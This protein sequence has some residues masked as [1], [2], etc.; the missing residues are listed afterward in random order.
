M[1]GRSKLKRFSQWK[2]SAV[3]KSV[4][5]AHSQHP[6]SSLPSPQS[7][8]RSHSF[9]YPTQ[10]LVCVQ[11]KCVPR[12]HSATAGGREQFLNVT[13][14]MAE[15]PSNTP[16]LILARATLK[17][18]VMRPSCTVA[19]FHWVP[20]SNSVLQIRVPLVIPFTRRYMSTPPTDMP[21]L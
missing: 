21:V 14:S 17:G 19:S 11:W 6:S 9:R 3:K 12:G 1:A 18:C 10:A 5:S 2:C 15:M 13:S 20:W 16:M 7:S 4:F 8:T